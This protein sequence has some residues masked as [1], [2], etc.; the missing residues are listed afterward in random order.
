MQV[1]ILCGGQ[2]TRI[3]DVADDVP[4]P[5]IPIGNRPILWHI[6]KGYAQHGFNR[7][8]LC[9][10]YKGWAIKRYFLDYHLFENN[11]SIRLGRPD[12][13]EL[14][15]P[16]VGEDWHVTLVETGL[17]AMTGCRVKR[18]ERYIEGDRF[19]L[20][21][22][23][24]VSDVDLSELVRFHR[25]HGK[26][27]T[28]TAVRQPGRFGELEQEGDRV[29]EFSEKPLTA[30]GWING[31]FFVFERAVFD[32]LRDDVNLVFEQQPLKDLAH[33]D[34]LMAYKHHGFWHPMD[35][36]RDYRFLNDLWNEGKAPW[37]TWAP[38]AVRRAA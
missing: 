23:D 11:F 5:I 24:G 37:K 29:T 13:V 28:V 16:A 22:G 20:T 18:V 6:M 17:E 7:F 9:L 26:V 10:G 14:H 33:N 4:K 1:V 36:S 27:G 38:G 34:E 32:Y 3:R 2:G 21:Y 31:G 12:S 19:L 25:G 35:S 8:V 15:G 30:R